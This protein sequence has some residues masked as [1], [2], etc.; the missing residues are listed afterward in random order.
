MSVLFSELE[1][2][3]TNTN[4]VLAQG[5]ISAFVQVAHLQLIDCLS[6]ECEKVTVCTAGCKRYK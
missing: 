2:A 5:R 1:K 4:K 3:L 6:K